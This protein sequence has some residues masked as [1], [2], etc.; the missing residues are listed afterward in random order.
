MMMGWK[1]V[2]GVLQHAHRRL[3]FAQPPSV[4]GLPTNSEGRRDRALP[5]TASGQLGPLVTIYLDGVSLDELSGVHQQAV[6]GTRSPEV[7][8][9]QEI[10]SRRGVPSQEKK[11]V[12]RTDEWRTLGCRVAG[13][14]GVLA[15]LRG[16]ISELLEL[17]GWFCDA[18]PRSFKEFHILADGRGAFSSGEKLPALSRIC[19]PPST[20][21]HAHKSRLWKLV[22]ICLWP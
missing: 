21:M 4:A 10:C 5:Q 20:R 17:T 18:T 3:C 9:L 19:C 11:A 14:L 15:P 2:C 12:Y 8:A 22:W 16:V 6:E 7:A 13:T 1:S